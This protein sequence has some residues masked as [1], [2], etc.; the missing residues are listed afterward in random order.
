VTHDLELAA[1]TQN[2]LRLKGG[3]I[4]ANNETVVS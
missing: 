2:I 1:K 3:K 4:I